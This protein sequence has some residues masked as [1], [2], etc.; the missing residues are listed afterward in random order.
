MRW[1]PLLLAF[2]LVACDTNSPD[3]SSAAPSLA[4][5]S[6]H[7]EAEG[8]YAI[9]EEMLLHVDGDM[10]VLEV[11]GKTLQFTAGQAY[12]VGQALSRAGYD[13]MDGKLAAGIRP[14]KGGDRCEPP[15]AGSAVVVVNGTFYGGGGCPPPPPPFMMTPD[16]LN[17]LL[18]GRVEITEAPK[19]AVWTLQPGGFTAPMERF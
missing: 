13:T 14:P 16:L 15:P 19:H 6:A 7:G 9:S 11:N 4:R 3:A 2:L 5:A 18:G 12:L 1:T 8:P 17:G 10:L